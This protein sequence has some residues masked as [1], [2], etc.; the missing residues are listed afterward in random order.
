MKNKIYVQGNEKVLGEETF[1]MFLID[2]QN[3]SFTL[4][5]FENIG[6]KTQDLVDD[7]WSNPEFFE[8]C[9]HR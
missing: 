5:V 2:R 4:H 1:R 8:L 7:V 3:Y 9:M 6:I